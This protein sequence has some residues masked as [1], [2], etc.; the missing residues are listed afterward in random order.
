M[1]INQRKFFVSVLL[2]IFVIGTLA[3]V[4]ARSRSNRNRL[5]SPQ[6]SSPTFLQTQTKSIIPGN[7]VRNLSRQ[8][9]A[10]NMSRRLGG[11]FASGK[12]EKSVLIGTLTI[13]S[14]RRIVQTTRTQT[15]DG[16]QVE[17]PIDGSAVSLDWN[18][19]GG[20][21]SF[22]SPATRS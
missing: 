13:G 11:R 7:G 20:A 15:D 16:E 8:P 2:A 9:D 10:F 18:R 3:L 5:P 6:V 21:L 1:L 12:R 17:M 19:A 14:E 22:S 4:V